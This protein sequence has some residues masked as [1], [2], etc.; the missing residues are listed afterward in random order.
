M[1]DL[2]N[3]N[4]IDLE[5]LEAFSGEL[6]AKYAKQ[7]AVTALSGRVKTLEDKNPEANVITGVKV[8][9]ALLELVDKVADI[10]VA[11]SAENGKIK[12]NNVDV[13]V[14]GLAALAFKAEVAE[15]DL[16]A[17]LKAA[18]DAKA[19][20]S[21]LDTL[22]GE[23]DGSIKK[24]IDAAINKFA[25]DISENDTVDT[26]KELVDWVAD[27]GSEAAEMA[28]GIE[29]NDAAIKGLKT[30]IGEIPSSASSST[31]VAYIAEAI[32]ALSIGDYAK[33]TEVEKK[34]ADA[35]GNVYNKQEV[36]NKLAGYVLAAD[37][38]IAS[39]DEVKALLADDEDE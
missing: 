14:H 18:I 22:T 7:S 26:F 37:I 6:K 12:V 2:K 34:I 32:A 1:A 8:N 19:K 20:Q 31:I 23:G 25:N 30:L 28:A 4:L 16:A 33:T 27:H 38:Q 35:I 13:A 3:K 36:D 39:A 29:A 17:A 10:L 11:E 9:G 24:M 21:D 15:G 5:G